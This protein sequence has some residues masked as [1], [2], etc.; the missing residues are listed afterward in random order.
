MLRD[1]APIGVIMVARAAPGSFSDNEVK[2]MEAFADQAVI[3]IEN[4][5]LFEEVQAALAHQTATADIL[6]VIS[7]SPTDVR[8]VFQAIAER[9]RELCN[10]EIGA[11][12][13]LEG[14]VV[15]LAGVRGP[16]AQSEQAMRA[17][18]PIARQLAPAN[19]QE[20]LARRAPY[21][22]FDV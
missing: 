3:A 14:D 10:A 22:I 20:A 18:F 4:A 1:G 16:S 12:S 5:R 11:T 2:L 21:Q 6:A 19:I 13:R 15:H 17:F 7:E 9:A 8:P